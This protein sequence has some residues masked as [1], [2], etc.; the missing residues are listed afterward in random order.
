MGFT[1]RLNEK[2]TVDWDLFEGKKHG[3]AFVELQKSAGAK[4]VYDFSV[5]VNPYFLSGSILEEFYA[6][7]PEYLKYYPSSNESISQKLSEYLKVNPETLVMANGSTELITWIDH[8]FIQESLLTSVPTFGR[9]TD[10]SASTGKRVELYF[11]LKENNFSIDLKDFVT[12]VKKSKVRSVVICNP[13]NPT[14]QILQKKELVYLLE[15]L[16]Y[17][18]LLI[19]DESF[20]DFSL[21][22]E[23]PT[24][25]TEVKNYKNL[26]V[27]KS[28]GKSLGM[29]GVRLGYAVSS[30]ERQ[31]IL[32]AALPPWNI[33]GT[34]VLLVELLAKYSEAFEVSRRKTVLDRLNFERQLRESNLLRF[35]P[36]F[37]NFL[38]LETNS[39]QQGLALRNTLLEDHGILTRECS[40][41]IGSTSQYMRV[42][43]RPSSEQKYFLDSLEAAMEKMVKWDSSHMI[44]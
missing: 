1:E 18:D 9:W 25:A 20:I 32:R 28:L 31:R 10:Q 43:S 39:Q 36:S 42:A 30:V 40:T 8:L 41:K 19:V 38:F 6:Q 35:Y 13:N 29:H 44:A 4:A 15:E 3:P 24:I 14:G 26:I 17:L 5:P 7:L 27:L 22:N 11:R 16:K 2:L 23:I 33:N 12:Q 37:S 34:G 21:E